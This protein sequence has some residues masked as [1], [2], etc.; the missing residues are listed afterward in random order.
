MN[1]RGSSGGHTYGNIGD[2]GMET[3]KN[4]AWRRQSKKKGGRETLQSIADHMV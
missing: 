1:S 4:Y 3:D 2:L